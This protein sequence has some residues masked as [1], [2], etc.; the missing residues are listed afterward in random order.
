MVAKDL[1]SYDIAPVKTSDTG[2]VIIDYLF[3][4]LMYFP[5]SI[6]MK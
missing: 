4:G 5:V 6:L 1:I 2:L 3:S